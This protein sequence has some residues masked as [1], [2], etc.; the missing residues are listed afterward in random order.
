MGE[1]LKF[2]GKEWRQ[3]RVERNR[4]VVNRYKKG[5]EGI[6]PEQGKKRMTTTAKRSATER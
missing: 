2:I 6:E 3:G 1:D 4:W 5:L